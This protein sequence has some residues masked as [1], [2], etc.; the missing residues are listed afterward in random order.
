M[1][2]CI[3]IM[4]ITAWL[5]LNVSLS[6]AQSELTSQPFFLTFV[7]NIQFSPVY[8]AIE[9]GYYAQAG[10]DV[11]IEHGDEPVGVDLI[12]AG[13]RQFGMISGEQLLTARGRGRP[14]VFVYEWFQRYPVGIVTSADSDIETAADLRG[15]RVGIPGRFGASYSGLTA[16]LNANGLSETDID[17]R[18]IGF[19]A[20]EVFCIGGVDASVVYVNNEPLQIA[21][22]AA[23][24]DCGTVTDVRVLPV[25]G[26]VDMVSNGIV[27]NEAAI[28]EQP[29]LVAAFVRAFD[30]G[31][32]DT[33]ANPART[34]LIS[35][36][37]VENLPRSSELAAAMES[38]ADE[39]DAWLRE[40]PDADREMIA[41]RRAAMLETLQADVEPDQLIQFEVLLASI[42]LW[43]AD[44]LG[45]T[46]P[47]SWETTQSI[48]LQMGFMSAPLADLDA[49]YTN[50]FVPAM[51]EEN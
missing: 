15:R 25:A 30:R 5:L 26:A 38:L 46:D 4:V 11:V 40:N 33:I 2:K 47:E 50:A 12:A 49:A 17:L 7:P 35:L 20:P 29:E 22:R 42:T 32:R 51:Q 45:F 6:G 24:G 37:Y 48:L 41:A 3:H 27:T 21:H 44:R 36:A 19:N 43:D 10:I 13:E 18:E 28:A 31:L 34:Y 14:V 23:R 39:Q 9:Q 16:L 8:V 1:R